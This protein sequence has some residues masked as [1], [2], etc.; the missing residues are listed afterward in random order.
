MG[1]MTNTSG[2]NAPNPRGN[3]QNQEPG[4]QPGIDTLEF[5]ALTPYVDQIRAIIH[6]LNPKQPDTVTIDTAHRTLIYCQSMVLRAFP[7]D[8]ETPYQKNTMGFESYNNGFNLYYEQ[9]KRG[10]TYGERLS[11][12]RLMEAGFWLEHRQVHEI[13]GTK[14][15]DFRRHDPN[16]QKGF[17]RESNSQTNNPENPIDGMCQRHGRS[18]QATFVMDRFEALALYVLHSARE[19]GIPVEFKGTSYDTQIYN[20]FARYKVN[21]VPM[22]L[23]SLGSRLEDR[24]TCV[25]AINSELSKIDSFDKKMGIIKPDDRISATPGRN[26]YSQFAEFSDGSRSKNVAAGVEAMLD[27]MSKVVQLTQVEL[28]KPITDSFYP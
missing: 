28:T 7:F 1:D 20:G 25:A 8:L 21:G 3:T 15:L 12:Q 11:S 18:M 10:G 13:A 5:Y 27:A 9:S 2:P 22:M 4:Q 14:L 19:R 17:D 23:A 24:M 16:I 6:A 26:G